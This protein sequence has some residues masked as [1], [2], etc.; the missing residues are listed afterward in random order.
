MKSLWELLQEY[1][2]K[3]FSSKQANVNLIVNYPEYDKCT[4]HIAIQRIKDDWNMGN[5]SFLINHNRYNLINPVLIYENKKYSRGDYFPIR[6]ESK[7][8]NKAI[9]FQLEIT[10]G[11]AGEQVSDEYETI[12]GVE[13]DI[14]SEPLNIAWRGVDTAVVTPEFQTIDCN[15]LITYK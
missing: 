6:M 13:F 2:N 7:F 11:E 14:V 9:A 8:G 12:C 1:W 3:Y 5:T 15:F 10:E 4:I